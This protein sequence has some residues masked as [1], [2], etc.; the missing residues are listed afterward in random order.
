MPSLPIA[1]TAVLE[2][3]TA[4]VLAV[5]ISNEVLFVFPRTTPYE[6]V[7]KLTKRIPGSHI[8]LQKVRIT[9]ELL[10]D[11]EIYDTSPKVKY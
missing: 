8:R 10:E 6:K 2:S 1:P 3:H 9:Y 5:A 4:T 7:K 11:N